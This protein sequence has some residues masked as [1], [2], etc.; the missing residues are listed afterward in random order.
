[1]LTASLKQQQVVPGIDGGF[2]V[3]GT[4]TRRMSKPEMNELIELIYAFGIEH[5]VK[6]SDAYESRIAES[7]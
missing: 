5:G 7:A 1:M 6:F 2:V 4:S 3:L